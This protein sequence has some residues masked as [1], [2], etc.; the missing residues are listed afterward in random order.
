[1]LADDE[2][3][4]FRDAFAELGD[5]EDHVRGQTRFWLNVC[6]GGPQY[7]SLRMLRVKHGLAKE[8]MTREGADR[9]LFHF[10]AALRIADLGP[11][12]TRVHRCIADFVGFFMERYA[13]EFDFNV[14]R[15][16]HARL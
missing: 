16:V 9:W 4:W 13:V 7:K 14:V 10:S 3:P 15:L 6:S 1:M 5:L 11:E 12:R 8:I 2:A